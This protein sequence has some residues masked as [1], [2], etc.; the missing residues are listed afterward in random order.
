MRLFINRSYE[1]PS[2][3]TSALYSFKAT[4]EL[5]DE[6]KMIVEQCSLYD[7]VLTRTQ[8]YHTT[9]LGDLMRGYID[10]LPDLSIVMGNEQA[11][12]EACES[13]PVIFAYCRSFGGGF[14]V[15]YPSFPKIP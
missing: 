11:L 3:K 12:R 15:E 1:A 5:S 6:E 10:S 9:K 13:L 4:L 8:S 14:V 2:R 7:Y